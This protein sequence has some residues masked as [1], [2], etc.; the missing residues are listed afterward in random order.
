MRAGRGAAVG[1]WEDGWERGQ[2]GCEE[3]DGRKGGGVGR[4]KRMKGIQFRYRRAGRLNLRHVSR[5]RQET[6]PNQG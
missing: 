3:G 5:G 6:H 2:K 1:D 4:G